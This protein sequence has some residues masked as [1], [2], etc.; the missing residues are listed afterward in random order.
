[1]LI[2]KTIY[3][4]NTYLLYIFILV[5]YKIL[6]Y[7]TYF[8]WLLTQLLIVQMFI[9]ISFT[10]Q[11]GHC[12]STHY[13]TVYSTHIIIQ[14]QKYPKCLRLLSLLCTCTCPQGQPLLRTFNKVYCPVD[15]DAA[16]YTCWKPSLLE[17]SPGE[18]RR[19]ASSSVSMSGVGEGEVCVP[20]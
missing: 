19:A 12:P 14:K 7:Y 2:Q 17:S 20:C 3:S 4:K 18:A 16:V 1:M 5:T 15:A 8:Y 11:L 9:Q 6:I 10:V 13:Y